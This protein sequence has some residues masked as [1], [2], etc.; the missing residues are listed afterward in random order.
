MKV[1]HL[2]SRQKLGLIDE[3]EIDSDKATSHLPEIRFFIEARRGR[4]HA[5]A[6]GDATASELEPM[7]LS[8][9]PI[10]DTTRP[11]AKSRTL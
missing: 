10:A 1:L 7:P 3:R 2:L 11:S 6:R 9:A 4:A 8:A 5:C